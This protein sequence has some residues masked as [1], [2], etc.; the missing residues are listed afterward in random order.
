MAWPW[1]DRTGKFSWFKAVTCL[2]LLIPAVVMA[3]RAP[4]EARFFTF[5]TLESGRWAIRLLLLC[6]AVTPLRQI[7]RLAKLQLLRRLIG[8][9]AFAYLVVHF[10]AYVTDLQFDLGKVV[11]EIWLRLYLTVG[12]VALL[13]L[14]VLTITSL[15]SLVKKLGRRWQKLHRSVYLAVL[16]GVIHFYLQTKLDTREPTLMAGIFLWLM[17]YRCLLWFKNAEVARAPLAL[18]ALTLAVPVLTALTEMLYVWINNGVDPLKVL[19]AN[20]RFAKGLRPAWWI[21]V[22]GLLLT[23]L[24]KLRRW[25]NSRRSLKGAKGS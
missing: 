16:L 17:G 20:L 12:F 4:G 3:L 6:L 8:V 19:E 1:L 5:L 24:G 18:L 14:L 7:A 2:L 23:L 15:D 13:I 22:G 11:S 21:L 25:Q 10:V 9:T